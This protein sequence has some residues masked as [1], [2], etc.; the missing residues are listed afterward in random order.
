VAMNPKILLVYYSRSGNTRVLAEALIQKLG[1]EWVE[2][3]PKTNYPTGA[4]GFLKALLHSMTGR[5]PEIE[6]IGKRP[7]YYEL[8]IV[9]GP[10]WGGRVATPVR[11]FLRGHQKNLKRVAFFATQGGTRAG[12][13]AMERMQSDAGIPPRA[14]LVIPE[15]DLRGHSLKN[16]IHGF[17]ARLNP[18]LNEIQG[19][20]RPGLKIQTSGARAGDQLEHE[21]ARFLSASGSGRAQN[22]K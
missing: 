2:L 22:P 18:I 10:I 11:S 3:R 7:E 4:W 20:L 14:S 19:P 1:C 9:G 13:R 8:V 6:V 17:L 12:E 15:R 16:S 21:S 5:L